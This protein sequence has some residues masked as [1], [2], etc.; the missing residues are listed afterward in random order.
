MKA[1]LLTNHGGP[2]VSDPARR[3]SW[4]VD[5]NRNFRVGSVYDGYSGAST[6]PLSQT[7]AGPE[8]LSEPEARNEVWLVEN[9]P[10][11]RFAMNVH[12]Y[13]DY[14]MWPPG[15]YRVPAS[16]KRRSARLP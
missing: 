14:F 7:Y 2:E 3:N 1:V 16:T 12:S 15:A 4:G 9:F 13:G 6:D 11:I 8:E 5:I 10:N